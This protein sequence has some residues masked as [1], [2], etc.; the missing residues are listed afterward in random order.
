M[1][2]IRQQRGLDSIKPYVP[3]TPIEEVQRKYGIKD[4]I[5]LASNENPIGPSPLA[6][7]A[8]ID[9]V[10]GLNYYPD[11]VSYYL[12]EAISEF[13]GLDRE[14]VFVDNGADGV[15]QS[16]CLAYLQDGDEV[17]VGQSSFPV[18]DIDVQVMRAKLVKTP[19]KGYGLDLAAMAAAVNE[20]T[21]MI[22]VCNPNNP[23]G[24]YCP[25]DEVADFFKRIPDH[26]LV[27]F[28]EAYYEFVDV[29]DFPDTLSLIRQRVPNAVQLRTMSKVYGLAGLRVGYGLGVPEVLAPLFVVKGSFSVNLLAQ[30]GGVAA[31]KDEAFLKR[32][33]SE[34]LRE[35][36]FLYDEFTRLGRDY[37]P[38]QTN[39]ILLHVGPQAADV[40]TEAL[41]M[42]VIVR[43]CAQYELPEF[44]RITIGTREQNI[45]LIEVLSKILKQ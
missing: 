3:G 45:R 6:S 16:L 14:Q 38:S 41:K 8:V 7:Q 12:R 34:T 37:V 23:T 33:V 13:H 27:V 20:R 39:F 21:K 11:G 43:P 25:A 18:Y 31:L 1:T 42:G 15:I 40:Y 32:S 10:H 26:V 19:R 29:P 22:F 2:K 35:R 17:I 9:A 30:A 28:D 24:T 36:K 4:V 5:K 44:L